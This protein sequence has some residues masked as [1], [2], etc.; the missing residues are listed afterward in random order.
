VN[1]DGP[2]RTDIGV[3]NLMAGGLDPVTGNRAGLAGGT[4]RQLVAV[5]AG[6]R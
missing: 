3:P 4:T 1:A 5:V 6:D 2:V